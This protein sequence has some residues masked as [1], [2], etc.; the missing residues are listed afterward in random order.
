MF[1]ITFQKMFIEMF[2]VSNLSKWM[3]KNDACY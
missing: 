2:I 1:K 3:T